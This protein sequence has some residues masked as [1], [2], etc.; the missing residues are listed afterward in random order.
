MTHTRYLLLALILTAPTATFPMA[1]TVFKRLAPA[2]ICG[3]AC[4]LGLTNDGRKTRSAVWEAAQKVMTHTTETAGSVQTWL[5]K[6]FTDQQDE[7][8]IMINM[9][10]EQKRQDK[11]LKKQL[12]EHDEKQD[13]RLAALTEQMNTLQIMIAAQQQQASPAKEGNPNLL[14]TRGNMIVET[15]EAD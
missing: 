2:T 5:E 15:E 10:A 9:L 12:Q 13:E 6:K 3:G 7:H 8:S 4:Y 1:K 11:K 14:V